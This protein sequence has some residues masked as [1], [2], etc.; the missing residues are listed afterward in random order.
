MSTPSSIVDTRIKQI[1]PLIPPACLLEELPVPA[2]LIPTI[3]HARAAASAIIHRA[4]DRLLVVIGPCSI[5]DP[6]AAIEYAQRLLPLAT[7]YASTLLLCMRVYFEKPRTTVGWKG[8]INDPLLDGSYAINTG[9][10][11]S[12][13]LMLDINRVGLPIACE[14]LDTITPQFISDLV[15]WGAIGARTTESQLHRE[16]VS[17]LSF[18]IGFKNGTGGSKKIAVDAIIASQ[19]PHCFLSVTTQGLAAIVETEGN[20]DC[21]IVLRGSET[22]T[23]YSSS[24]IDETEALMT[25]AKLATPSIMIDCSHGNSAKNHANQPQVIDAVCQLLRSG[26]ESVIGVMVESNLYEGN[27]KLECGVGVKERLRYGVSVTDACIGW[28]STEAVLKELSE[29]VEA[30]R[31]VR[32]GGSV[33]QNGNGVS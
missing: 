3:Q 31:R 20:A 12:R 10:R 13:K 14:M 25:K 23:N 22:G 9:L 18:P 30:R 5:H 16:L 6:E 21:H 33:H 29:A 15:A 19:S 28:E 24:D 7:Q 1:R 17:G 4:D 8:L 2:T 11:T 32:G 26:R 27:Q